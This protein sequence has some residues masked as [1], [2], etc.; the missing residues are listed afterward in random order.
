MLISVL[1][2]ESGALTVLLILLM[3]LAIAEVGLNRYAAEN[4]LFDMIVP[5]VKFDDAVVAVIKTGYPY[6]DAGP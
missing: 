1:N 6:P 4:T 5:V 3:F 2:I